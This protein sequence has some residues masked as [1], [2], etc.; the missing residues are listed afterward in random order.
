MSVRYAVYFSPERTALARF[1]ARTLGI[2]IHRQAAA[3]EQFAL[4]AVS[5]AD[6]E[7]LTAKA[8][9]YGFHATIKAPFR[10]S[11]DQT[12]A[13]LLDFFR[14]FCAN[15]APALLP[16]TSV[17]NLHGFLSIMP[18]VQPDRLLRLERAVVSAFEPFRAPLTASEV[19]RRQPER[20]SERQRQHLDQFGYPFVFDDF[21][22][23]MTLTGRLTGGAAD[24]ALHAEL[25]DLYARLVPEA[26]HPLDS[27]TLATQP[28]PSAPF[29]ALMT[30]ALG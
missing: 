10:L 21:R 11:S 26:D 28:T 6:F 8:R 2:D 15:A 9:S 23:H 4:N 12:E 20:L 25:Q 16:Q 22:F 1:G 29:T 19:D 18:A 5:V 3:V 14:A 30:C 13:E 17:Q 24:M 7:T 27:L